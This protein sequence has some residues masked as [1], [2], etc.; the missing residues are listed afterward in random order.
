MK[1]IKNFDISGVTPEFSE[2]KYIPVFESNGQIEKYAKSIGCKI[3]FPYFDGDS[4]RKHCA[5]AFTEGTYLSTIFL[6]KSCDTYEFISG[7]EL[8]W[9][10]TILAFNSF[11]A[12]LLSN[13]K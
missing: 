1:F 12:N 7:M 10:N 4:P 2:K 9:Q 11:K 5:P 3:W 13:L 8:L 6:S